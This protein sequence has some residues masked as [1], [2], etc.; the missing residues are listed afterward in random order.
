MLTHHHKPT[1]GQ[2]S[3][4]YECC[5]SEDE[6]TEIPTDIPPGVAEVRISSP[7]IATVKTDAFHQLSYCTY[8]QIGPNISEIEPRAF[9][10]L[11]ALTS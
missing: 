1:V 6:L 9:N 8:L 10:G 5:E 3:E 7:T 11:R 2:S 4:R